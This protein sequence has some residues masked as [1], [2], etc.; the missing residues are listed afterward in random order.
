MQAGLEEAFASTCRLLRG[1]APGSVADVRGA[2]AVASEPSE[3]S[4]LHVGRSVLT[5]A[6]AAL[7][8]S[9]YLRGLWKLPRVC[10]LRNDALLPAV[11]SP[12]AGFALARLCSLTLTGQRDTP[13]DV[14]F[15]L[16][17]RF[18]SEIH[19]ATLDSF[20]PSKSPSCCFLTS[21]S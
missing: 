6:G 15:L 2:P 19:K 11:C 17:F 14:I 9:G 4:S 18:G 20:F 8:C 1:A 16:P 13:C 7:T 5:L 21:S 3:A 12:L 10:D